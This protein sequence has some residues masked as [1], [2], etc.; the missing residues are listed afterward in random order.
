MRIN[1]D[2]EREIHVGI[3][4][5]SV[6]N[7]FANNGRPVGGIARKLTALLR[8]LPQYFAC[9]FSVVSSTQGDYH[10]EELAPH[11]RFYDATVRNIRG[12]VHRFFCSSLPYYWRLVY[13]PYRANCDVYF[14]YS[15][16]LENAFLWAAATLRRR[17]CI[18][19][20]AS[21]SG[22]DYNVYLQSGQ[23]RPRW[24]RAVMNF[25]IRHS[26]R[27]VVQ[28][29]EQALSFQNI[30]GREA[31][32]IPNMLSL[33][34]MPPEQ[35][36]HIERKSILFLGRCE[37]IKRPELFLELARALPQFDFVM[38]A[39]RAESEPALQDAIREPAAAL[40]N[41]RFV[42]GCRADEVTAHYAAARVFILSSIFEGF[43]NVMAEAMS[44]G[45]PVI[46]YSFAMADWFHDVAPAELADAN[47]PGFQCDGDFERMVAVTT[48]LMTDDALWTR[49]A[50]AANCAVSER[51]LPA[52]V[53]RQYETLFRETLAAW[54]AR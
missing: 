17:P 30:Y 24:Y 22:I 33:P 53:A 5:P 12:R 14:L 1:N 45:T 11:V 31:T 2:I 40:P 4:A 49:C 50:R 26:F 32:V 27:V 48:A 21:L 29:K 19:S 28:T 25:V 37:S 18:F 8:H 10:D 41:V 13:Y 16:F 34:T 7:C 38:V 47:V 3:S 42:P 51:I 44:Q 54:D 43:P 35:I 52:A 39:S 23:R 9:R 6:Y 46:S 20:F 15:N 36:T